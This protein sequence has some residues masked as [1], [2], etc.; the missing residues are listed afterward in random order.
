M[1]NI[2]MISKKKFKDSE[3]SKFQKSAWKKLKNIDKN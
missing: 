3:T 1:Q 2:K